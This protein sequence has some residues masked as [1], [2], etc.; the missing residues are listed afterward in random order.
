M[1]YKILI[2]I[3]VVTIIVF[4]L[5]NK[6]KKVKTITEHFENKL[7][8][9][10]QIDFTISKKQNEKWPNKSKKQLCLEFGGVNADADAEVSLENSSQITIACKKGCVLCKDKD[11]QTKNNDCVICPFGNH[12]KNIDLL[13]EDKK[14]LLY[15]ISVAS[16]DDWFFENV[17]IG[18]WDVSKVTDMSY[19]FSKQG[20]NN[21]F[22]ENIKKWDVSN[23]TNMTQMFFQCSMFVNNTSFNQNIGKWDLS[24]VVNTSGMLYG[25]QNFNQDISNWNISKV[26]D[27]STMFSNCSNFNQN[28]AKWDVSS[29]INSSYMFYGCKKFNQDLSSWK[30]VSDVYSNYMFFNSAICTDKLPTSIKFDSLTVINCDGSYQNIAIDMDEYK[31]SIE[32]EMNNSVQENQS[33]SSDIG[34]PEET[35]EQQEEEVQEDED[36]PEGNDNFLAG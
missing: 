7:F 8:N 24:N 14:Q 27:T 34:I 19:L 11:K 15:F 20:I 32:N 13:V 1:N 25:C 12:I 5:I 36:I 2:L 9:C 6:I 30:L 22:N 35:V 26:T 16:E 18:D 17:H 33:A 29:I 4:I 28:I 10:S 21:T 31:E 3:L 23:V